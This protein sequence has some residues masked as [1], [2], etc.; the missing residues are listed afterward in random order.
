MIQITLTTTE[1]RKNPNTK[2]SYITIETESKVIDSKQHGLITNEDTCKWFRRL[3]GS[4]TKTMAY[5]CDGYKCVKLI[6]T[7]P[8]RD[9]K[10][11]R[12]FNFKWIDK[13]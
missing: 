8:D 2:T 3:G 6:S 4:E 11:I 12:E 10:K 1:Q 9:I 5:T 7:S 13:D